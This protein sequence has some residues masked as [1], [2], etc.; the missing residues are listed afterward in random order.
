MA[1]SSPGSRAP[2]TRRRESP[3]ESASAAAR[4]RRARSDTPRVRS[5]IPRVGG[6]TAPA[7]GPRPG[8][9]PGKP[10]R[11]G[12]SRAAPGVRTSRT[13]SPTHR[14]PRASP[15]RGS[16]P[17]GSRPRRSGRS[18]RRSGRS[19]RCFR[20][21][22]PHASGRVGVRWAPGAGP[23]V[24]SRPPARPR[25]PRHPPAARRAAGRAR[26]TSATPR[27]W[28]RA[29]PRLLRTRRRVRTSGARRDGEPRRRELGTRRVR[30]AESTPAA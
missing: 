18:R 7:G 22:Q 23:T 8:T 26:T 5:D 20:S 17:R 3:R 29:I 15:R 11:R 2:P 6:S 12:P 28:D 4:R 30:P 16:R 14:S 25:H 9:R 21:R 10:R 24:A 27:R 13:C 19:L 1:P